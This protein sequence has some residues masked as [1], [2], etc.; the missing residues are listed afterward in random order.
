MTV[1]GTVLFGDKDVAIA[2]G[3]A[4]PADALTRHCKG[5]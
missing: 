4:N 1:N 3:Y 2:L 5:V